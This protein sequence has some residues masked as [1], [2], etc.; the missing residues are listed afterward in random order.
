MTRAPSFGP[1]HLFFGRRGHLSLEYQLPASSSW[2][3]VVLLGAHDHAPSAVFL[4]LKDWTTR[5]DQPIHPSDQVRGYAEYCRQFHSAVADHA[6]AVHGCVLFTRDRW[7]EGY[8]AAPNAALAGRYPLFTMAPID[9]EDRFPAY[10]RARL[11]GPDEEFARAFES[12]RYRQDRGFIRQIASR[13]TLA[14]AFAIAG[15]AH[16]HFVL[17]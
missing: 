12:G 8:S 14:L 9:V 15:E 13:S 5:G 17:R 3:D 6:A 2:C 7:I 10:F 16:R 11:T 4:E 1:L